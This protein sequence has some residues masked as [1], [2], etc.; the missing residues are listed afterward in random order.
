MAIN[1]SHS[2]LLNSN[3]NVS[4]SGI[5]SKSAIL[6]LTFKTKHTEKATARAAVRAAAKQAMK[7]KR[8]K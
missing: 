8:E 3:K 7:F 5:L 2:P 4:S 1:L 6:L